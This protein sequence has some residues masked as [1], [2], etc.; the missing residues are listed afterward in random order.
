MLLPQKKLFAHFEELGRPLPFSQSSLN[1]DRLD[2]RLGIRYC[3]IGGSIFYDTEQVQAWLDGIPV[4]I[5]AR[6]NKPVKPA[7]GRRG[8]P[9]KSESLEALRLGIS[10]PQLRAQQGGV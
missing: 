4:V 6:T 1:K 3:P 10:V 2:G 8:K 7:A 5:P 9:K